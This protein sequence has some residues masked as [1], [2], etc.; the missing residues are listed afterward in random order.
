MA[1]TQCGA[2][3][4]ETI[5]TDRVI[6]HRERDAPVEEEV[7]IRGAAEIGQLEGS[8]RRPR[9][10]ISEFVPCDLF[11]ITVR[12]EGR[13]DLRTR[14]AEVEVALGLVDE[15]DQVGAAG[16]KASAETAL[17]HCSSTDD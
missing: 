12:G 8:R 10:D 9:I 2:A 17:E 6:V 1:V 3:A 5:G 14:D 15:V 13:L 16:E 11:A 4:S 7:R